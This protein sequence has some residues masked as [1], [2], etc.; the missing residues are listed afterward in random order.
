[1]RALQS[2]LFAFFAIGVAA[3][4]A[5]VQSHAAE[6]ATPGAATPPKAESGQKSVSVP[7]T[8]QEC[9]ALGGDVNPNNKECL[10]KGQLTCTTT[11]VKN[12]NGEI[13]YVTQSVCIDK[14]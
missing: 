6:K 7:L 2:S 11:T 9:D 12:I 13:K 14:K 10:D 5:G 1:M 3:T 4:S 8:V